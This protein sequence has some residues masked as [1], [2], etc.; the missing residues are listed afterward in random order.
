MVNRYGDFN[1]KYVKR[2]KQIRE[3]RKRKSINQKKNYELIRTEDDNVEIKLTTSNKKELK[4][5]RIRQAITKDCNIE[6]LISKR[7]IKRKDKRNKRYINE[8][9]SKMDIDNE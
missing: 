9:E 4:R 5:E 6:K 3:K 7:R 2:T 1:R 8:K